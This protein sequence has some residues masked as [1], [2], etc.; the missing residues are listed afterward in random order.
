MVR[1][2]FFCA[3][4]ALCGCAPLKHATGSASV[5]SLRAALGAEG[6]ALEAPLEL[7][8]Q[9][10]ARAELEVGRQG[11]ERDR[12]ERLNRFLRAPG[13]VGFSYDAHAT[14]IAREAWRRGSGDCLSFA[15]LFNALARHLGVPVKYVRYRD[16]EGFEERGGQFTVVTHVASLYAD[17]TV[18]VLVEL[19]GRPPSFRSSDYQLITD[20][21]ALALHAS[22]L[23]MEELSAGE[24]ARAHRWLEALAREAPELPEVQNN[25]AVALMRLG[26]HADALAVLE[27]ALG[28][29]SPFQPLYVNAALAARALGQPALAERYAETAR[30]SWGDPFLPFVRATWLYEQG[31]YGAAVKLFERAQGLEPRSVLFLAWLARARLQAGDQLGARAAF[32][33]AVEVNPLHPVLEEFHRLHP[34]LAEARPGPRPVEELPLPPAG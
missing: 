14:L 17:H 10:R 6:L 15:H 19:T 21:E 28:R 23:A 29:F 3:M 12:L 5:A 22:N 32:S 20:A 4:L 27:R 30:S 7:T 13:G 1:W 25:H 26:R 33:Q 24:V 9:M 18:N 31:K 2:L 16:A 34:A 11:T 8:P